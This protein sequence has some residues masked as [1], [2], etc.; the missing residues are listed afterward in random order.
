MPRHR[1]PGNGLRCM[2][3]HHG[4]GNR[5]GMHATAPQACERTSLHATAPRAWERTW[6]ACHGTAGLRTDF[7]ACHGTTGLGTD[8][9]CMPLPHAQTCERPRS[10]GKGSILGVRERE[11]GVQKRERL[12]R[13]VRKKGGQGVGKVGVRGVPEQGGGLGQGERWTS[14]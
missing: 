9:G 7:A 10:E 3:R 6:D 14:V 12:I 4:P 2:P 5:L 1:R 13:G 8:L 11:R